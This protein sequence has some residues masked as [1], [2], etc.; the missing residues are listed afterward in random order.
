MKFSYLFWSF[1]IILACASC[2]KDKEDD[3][4]EG[5]FIGLWELSGNSGTK[6]LVEKQQQSTS[7]PDM[8]L[9]LNN[10]AYPFKYTFAQNGTSIILTDMTKETTD[11]NRVKTYSIILEDKKLTIPP[12]HSTLGNTSEVTFNKVR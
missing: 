3:S 1:L 11:E 8:F 2:K 6:L 7:M 9:E 4:I 12:F 5:K 10:T